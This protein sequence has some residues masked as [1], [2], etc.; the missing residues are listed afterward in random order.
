MQ[1]GKGFFLRFLDLFNSLDNCLETE[2]I[3]LIHDAS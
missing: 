1:I 3:M 2:D